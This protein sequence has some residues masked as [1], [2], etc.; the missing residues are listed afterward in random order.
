MI[1][2]RKGAVL[3]VLLPLAAGGLSACLGAAGGVAGAVI[4]ELFEPG[5]TRLEAKMVADDNLNPDYSGRPSPLVVRLYAL[6]NTVAF[7][8]TDFFKL[9]ES[10][11]GVLGGDLLNRKEYQLKPGETKEIEGELN[12]E[13]EFL[14]I[15]AAYQDIDNAV[16]RSTVKLESHSTNE[17]KIQFKSTQVVA[18]LED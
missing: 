13:V 1:G 3:A 11:V 6:K 18:S 8:N 2:W 4:G 5:P 9:Y 7:E 15:L 16:W 12:E 10:D 17:V 14:G